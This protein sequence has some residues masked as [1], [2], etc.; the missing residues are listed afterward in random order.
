[1]DAGEERGNGIRE[2]AR[3]LSDLLGDSRRLDEEREKAR[4]MS[5]KY[6]GISSDDY[7]GGFGGSSSGP[8]NSSGNRY[9]GFG[10]DD[11]NY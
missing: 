10:S 3:E 5:S 6:V 2:K 11:Y 4:S 9:G 8:G 7:R 1:M